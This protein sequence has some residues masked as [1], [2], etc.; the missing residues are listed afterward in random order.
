VEGWLKG[1]GDV[2]SVHSTAQNP[3]QEAMAQLQLCGEGGSSHAVVG[4]RVVE[5]GSA[6]ALRGEGI[7]G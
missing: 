4:G 5:G 2:R 6:A 3:F 1:G 7:E